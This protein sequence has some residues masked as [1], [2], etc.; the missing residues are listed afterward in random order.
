M[1]IKT[2]T[3][4]LLTAILLSGI[5]SIAVAQTMEEDARF[6]NE[7]SVQ[8]NLG[9]QKHRNIDYGDTSYGLGV[10]DTLKYGRHGAFVGIQGQRTASD[11]STFSNHVREKEY[12]VKAGYQYEYP[13]AYGVTVTPHAGLGYKNQILKDRDFGDKEEFRRG[14]AEIGVDGRYM[15][16]DGWA[17]GAGATYQRDLN[18]KVKVNNVYDKDPSRGYYAEVT[19]GVYKDIGQYGKLG[20]EPYYG[21]Y[22]NKDADKMRVTDTGVRVKYDF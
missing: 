3:N 13:M 18:N 15:L 19:T 5:S 20:V 8:T 16:K 7:V 2:K 22:R 6:K 10:K 21:Q 4:V 11:K 14:Y 9:H 1:Q 17:V 12:D